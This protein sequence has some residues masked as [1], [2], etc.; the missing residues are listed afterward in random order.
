MYYYTRNHL[1]I[2]SEEAF[3]MISSSIDIIFIQFT[4]VLGSN[5]SNIRNE[6]KY[7]MNTNKYAQSNEDKYSKLKLIRENLEKL[8]GNT[9]HIQNLLLTIVCTI[10]AEKG[11]NMS[12]VKLQFIEETPDSI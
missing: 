5:K 11:L 9:N 10:Q 8:G 1:P 4:Y 3:G 12:K 2:D 7:L 6:I